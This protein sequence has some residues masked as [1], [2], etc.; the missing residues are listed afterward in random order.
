MNFKVVLRHMGAGELIYTTFFAKNLSQ[1][2]KE[3]R[4]RF[5]TVY[6]IARTVI[7]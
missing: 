5:S 1:L 4:K 3:V 2:K 7:A 6:M